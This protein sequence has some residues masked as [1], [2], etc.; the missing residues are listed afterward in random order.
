MI[1][2]EADLRQYSGSSVASP[3][4]SSSVSSCSSSSSSS[5][6]SCTRTHTKT[7]THPARRGDSTKRRKTAVG[8]SFWGGWVGRSVGGCG[9]GG[10]LWGVHLLWIILVWIDCCVI[11]RHDLVDTPLATHDGNV[12]V[13]R[14]YRLHL[15]FSPITRVSKRNLQLAGRKRVKMQG[16]R[17]RERE[18]ERE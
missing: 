16:E 13:E 3:S 11:I 18:R 8:S 15:R 2:I 12:R 10:G 1:I 17:E 7:G 9:G 5:S 14:A 6:S 4:N